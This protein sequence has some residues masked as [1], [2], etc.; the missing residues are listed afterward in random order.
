MITWLPGIYR[1][2]GTT[3]VRLIQYV[4]GS[5]RIELGELFN[6]RNGYTPSKSKSEYWTNGTIPW[7]RLE[8]I[9]ENGRILSDSIQ[10][11]TKDAVKGELFPKDS[12]IIS[13]SATIGEHALVTQKFL[14]N[15]R[16]TCL[17][18]KENLTNMCDVKFLYYQCFLLREYC[19]KY[20]NQGNF[21]SVDMQMF[22]RFRMAIPP[23]EQQKR[24]IS[25]LDRFDTL[26]NSITSGIPAHI[27]AVEKQYEYY[28]NK[29]LTF[30]EK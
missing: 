15:Q 1:G 7:F 19:K 20:L 4:F 26:C 5:V 25:I 16:F 29:L 13:T 2:G 30:D 18:V 28:R 17:S 24:I 9:R 10:K 12:I 11:I 23:L 3:E 22:Y 6:V 21:A 14:A 27:N 8:D